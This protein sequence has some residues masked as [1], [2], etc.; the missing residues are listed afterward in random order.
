MTRIVWTLLLVIGCAAEPMESSPCDAAIATLERCTGT[1]PD[2]FREACDAAPDTVA[3]GVLA[4]IDVDSCPDAEMAGRSDGIGKRA[5]VEACAAGVGAAYWVVWARSESSQP[6]SARM[7][8]QLRPWFGDLVDTVRVSWNSG[9]LSQWRVF[10]RDVVF[11]QDTIA[12]TYGHEIFI[13]ES[14]TEDDEQIALVGHELGHARQYRQLG[15]VGGFARA[16][17]GA[18]Y[19]ANYSYDNNALELEAYAV[20]SRIE[21]C[22][23]YGIDC[24]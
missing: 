23:D 15:G 18:F 2:G 24:P 20:E 1:V 5:F 13:R 12:Q 17:C 7:K 10:G 21:S 4:E 11:D 9:L 22:L 6:L 8:G 19:D 14:P 3:N 16:Y